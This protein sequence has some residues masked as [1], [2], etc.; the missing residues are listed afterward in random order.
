V[1]W[2]RRNIPIYVLALILFL[3]A[4]AAFIRFFGLAFE[5]GDAQFLPP[6]VCDPACHRQFTEMNRQAGHWG[7]ASVVLLLSAAAL[8][9]T[10]WR[11]RRTQLRSGVTV[12][13]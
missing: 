1:K 4:V 7:I 10:A 11:L 8:V 2:R 12:L 6:G 3:F 5:V 9:F 13:R